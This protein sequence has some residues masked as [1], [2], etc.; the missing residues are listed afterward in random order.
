MQIPWELVGQIQT[1]IVSTVNGAA[2]N[3]GLVPVAPSSPGIFSVD[4]SGAGQGAILIAP[5]SQLAAP[6][7]AVPGR[8]IHLYLL[9]RSG[10]GCQSA[11]RRDAGSIQYTL[12]D[13]HNANCDHRRR[14]GRGQLPGFGAQLVVTFGADRRF[15]GQVAVFGQSP[16]RLRQFQ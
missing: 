10:T 12:E 14:G 16:F 13:P 9:H 7:S 4:A 5:T 2:S 15:Y 1:T 3:T 8:R 11:P 6:G